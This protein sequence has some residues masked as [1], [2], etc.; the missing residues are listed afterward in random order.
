MN[1]PNGS[2][3]SYQQGKEEYYASGKS[4]VEEFHLMQK[5]RE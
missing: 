3:I 1:E 5:D 2:E 4:H